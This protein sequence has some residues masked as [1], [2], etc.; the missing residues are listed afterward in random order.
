MN[1]NALEILS[2]NLIIKQTDRQYTGS[3]EG[4]I[5]IAFSEEDVETLKILRHIS[6]IFKDRYN[7]QYCDYLLSLLLH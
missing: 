7:I 5:N 4:I 6:E 2:M 1:M 3:L